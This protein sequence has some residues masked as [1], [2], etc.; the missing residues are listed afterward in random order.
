MG[1]RATS[2]V[3]HARSPRGHGRGVD[4]VG[5]RE[6]E[7]LA[8]GVGAVA[9]FADVLDHDFDVL[10]VDDRATGRGCAFHQRSCPNTGA[11]PFRRLTI[12][13]RHVCCQSL[14]TGAGPNIRRSTVPVVNLLSASNT[15]VTWAVTCSAVASRRNFQVARRLMSQS[16]KRV[17]ELQDIAWRPD[18]PRDTEFSGLLKPVR[19]DAL[20]YGVG[21]HCRR[22][23][24][25]PHHRRPFRVVQSQ[26]V[27]NFGPN[28]IQVNAI[29]SLI[30]EHVALVVEMPLAIWFTTFR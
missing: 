14:N 10:R 25:Q 6:Y 5:V 23:R 12:S 26:G 7:H 21:G 28:Q 22:I 15:R 1:K 8:T 18:C 13:R 9:V 2:A 30:D 4:I 17:T 19:A 16:L 20:R 24:K 27:R 11:A 3:L 29:C